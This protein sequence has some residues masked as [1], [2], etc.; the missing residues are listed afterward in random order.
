MLLFASGML[1]GQTNAHISKA[2]MEH[3]SRVPIPG[4]LIRRDGVH[5]AAFRESKQS[6]S[7][8]STNLRLPPT[9]GR[10]S[11]PDCV[12]RQNSRQAWEGVCLLPSSTFPAFLLTVPAAGPKSSRQGGVGAEIFKA[13]AL[14]I[15]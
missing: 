12:H 7:L 11:F 13:I 5:E 10:K 3:L 4:E 6:M 8:V 1:N 14:C 9:T 15:V 2:A